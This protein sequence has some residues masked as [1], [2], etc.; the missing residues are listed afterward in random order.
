MRKFVIKPPMV[1]GTVLSGALVFWVGCEIGSIW[2]AIV[3]FI[4]LFISVAYCSYQLFK[5]MTEK[6]GW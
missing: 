1:I 3:G 6:I 4:P 2:L 5:L